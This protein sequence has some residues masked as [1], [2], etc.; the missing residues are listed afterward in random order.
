MS[1]CL[2]EW[3]CEHLEE[4][5]GEKMKKAHKVGGKKKRMGK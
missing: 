5:R 3:K 1:W 4:Q 2:E